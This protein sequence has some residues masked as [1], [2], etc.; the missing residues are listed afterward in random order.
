MMLHL[1][2]SKWSKVEQVERNAALICSTTTSPSR[3]E[4]VWWS[5]GAGPIFKVEQ[6]GVEQR[7]A[8]T[9]SE[10]TK[11]RHT[12]RPKGSRAG[13]PFPGR[14]GHGLGW[15]SVPMTADPCIA[16]CADKCAEFGEPPCWQIVRDIGVAWE[17]C[18]DCLVEA[19][20]EVVDAIDPA[21]VVGLLL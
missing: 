9:C 4:V 6:N 3:R 14:I 1:E 18:E 11:T 19:G 10:I 13:D 17:A 7:L 15:G 12:S 20:C 8:A 21:A 2:N 16:I 5:S